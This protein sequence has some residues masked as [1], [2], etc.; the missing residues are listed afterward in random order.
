MTTKKGRRTVGHRARK[1]YLL[2]TTTVEHTVGNLPESERGSYEAERPWE[3]AANHGP[4]M[5]CFDARRFD[6]CS[7]QEFGGGHVHG[8][9]ALG[10]PT[11]RPHQTLQGHPEGLAGRKEFHSRNQESRVS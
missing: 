9:Q 6:R 3:M 11:G 4:L 7:N 2:R 10:R 8:E 5:Y 1:R